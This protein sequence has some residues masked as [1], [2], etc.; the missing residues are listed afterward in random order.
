VKVA[1]CTYDSMLHVGFWYKA[2]W[3]ETSSSAYWLQ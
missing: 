3:S 2:G 1:L